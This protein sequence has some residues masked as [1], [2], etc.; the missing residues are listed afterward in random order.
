MKKILN[1]FALTAM[2]LAAGCEKDSVQ[3]EDKIELNAETLVF[4]AAGGS[5]EMEVYSSG[6]WTLSDGEAWCRPSATSGGD[7]D[8]VTFTAEANADATERTTY[9]TFRCGEKAVALKATQQSVALSLSLPEITVGASGGTAEVEVTCGGTWTLSGGS[10]RCTP[11]ADSGKGGERVLF[12]IAENGDD[13]PR[14]AEFTFRSGSRTVPLPVTQECASL[15]L[16][17]TELSL[18]A[19]GGEAMLTVSSSGV[20]TLEGGDVWCT[21]SALTGGDED[22]VCFSAPENAGTELRSAEFI[23]VCGPKRVPVMVTQSVSNAP[24]VICYTS[25]DGVKI[26]PYLGEEAQVVSHTYELGEGGRIVLDRRITT[27]PYRMLDHNTDLLSIVIP[28]G[29]MRIE[30]TAF[31]DCI[32]LSSVTLPESLTRIEGASP[33]YSYGGAFM[34]C[35][36]LTQ[37]TLPAALEYIGSY[38]FSGTNLSRISI[39]DNSRLETLGYAA[40]SG[41]PITEITL[42]ASMKSIGGGAFEGCDKLVSVTVPKGAVIEDGWVCGAVACSPSGAFAGCTGLTS[43]TLPDDLTFL[44][45]NAFFGCTSLTSIDLPQTLERIGSNAFYGCT[46]LQSIAIP[47]NV[48]LIRDGSRPYY[49]CGTFM[50]CTSL[51]EVIIP[52]DSKLT[53]IGRFAFTN[54]TALESISLP[55]SLQE[56]SDNAFKGCSALTALRIPD[57]METFGHCVFLG[58]CNLREFSG[59]YAS[60]DGRMLVQY[61][62]LVA[63]A[64][65]GLTSYEIPDVEDGIYRIENYVFMGC[66]RLT[67]VKIPDGV[68]EI[69][70]N[71]FMDCTELTSLNI[72]QG[73]TVISSSMCMNCS[74]LTSIALPES[75]TVIE[76]SAFNGCTEL[77]TVVFPGLKTLKNSVFENCTKLTKIDLP[78]CLV[79]IDSGAFEGCKG[80]Y[81]IYCRPM[82]PPKLST[83]RTFYGTRGDLRIYV[84]TACVDAYKSDSSWSDYADRIEGYD[85]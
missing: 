34:G 8:K 13:E 38:V 39:P 49:D 6:A 21:P 25:K 41:V 65:G 20:W 85:F 70:Y 72:P 1:F 44:G 78:A 59:R 68:I 71:A 53:Y 14:S 67:S 10:D 57:K 4:A 2:L 61:G 45:D 23:F 37:I 40:F 81:G 66:G 82:T 80:L 27:I 75:V 62:V 30:S 11:S 79:S 51:R 17:T 52:D 83:W 3:R 47:A 12:T 7:G 48:A 56:I 18:D 50:D 24:S 43:V 15:S 76:S 28:E 77:R 36:N 58:C 84:P 33:S 64:P 5:F 69:G 22:V 9:F 46:A 35:T 16:S 63:F 54:C 60:P 73:M 32:N 26:E 31:R 29:V 55:E 42:P 19:E 74:S